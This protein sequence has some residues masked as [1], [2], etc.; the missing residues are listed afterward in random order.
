MRQ[1]IKYLLLIS[2]HRC[3]NYFGWMKL[4]G[5]YYTA[6]RHK[7]IS[8]TFFSSHNLIVIQLTITWFYNKGDLIA[9]SK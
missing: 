1:N 4:L 9:S 5:P 2:L 6:Q 3:E 7:L 8:H